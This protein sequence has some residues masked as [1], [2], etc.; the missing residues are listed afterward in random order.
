MS[1]LSSTTV[2]A[3]ASARRCASPLFREMRVSAGGRLETEARARN[4]ERIVRAEVPALYSA[5]NLS[6]KGHGWQESPLLADGTFPEASRSGRIGGKGQVVTTAAG[7]GRAAGLPIGVIPAE[8]RRAPGYTHALGRNVLAAMRQTGGRWKLPAGG[9]LR[10]SAVGVTNRSAIVQHFSDYR[11]HASKVH[12]RASPSAFKTQ[13][14]PA[15]R[16]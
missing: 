13:G 15:V 6:G 11:A 5:R 8:N 3:Y 1:Y 2:R 9:R 14:C 10:R 12:A 16:R 4:A 7:V